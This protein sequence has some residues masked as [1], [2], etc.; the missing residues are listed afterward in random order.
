MSDGLILAGKALAA[1]SLRHHGM[2]TMVLAPASRPTLP[3][4]LGAQWHL[5]HCFKCLLHITLPSTLD[6]STHFFLINI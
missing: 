6:L 3:P 5:P 2:L 4:S 1:C